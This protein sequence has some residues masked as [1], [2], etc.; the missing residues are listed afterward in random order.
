MTATA[1][2]LEIYRTAIP[3]R[4]FEHA[5]AS[6]DV[7]EAVLVR[8]GFSDGSAGWGETLPRRYVTGETIDTVIRNLSDT[9]WPACE[10]VGFGELEDLTRIPARAADGRCMHAAACAFE[11]A[12]LDRIFSGG[13]GPSLRR[14]IGARVSGVIGSADAGKTAG[15]LRRMLWFG[16]RDFKLKL[17]F[18]DDIDAENL[19]VVHKRLGR[20]IRRRRCTLRVDVNGGWSAD[21]TPGR[22][23]GLERYGVCV[24]EQPTYCSAAR[25]AELAGKCRLPLMADESLITDADADALLAG[26]QRPW[27]NIR[28]A[29]NG[30][31]RSLKM[32][33]RAAEASVRFTLG[34]MVGESSILSAAQRRMLQL[35]PRPM[36]VEGNY[37]RFLLADDLTKKSLRFG[38]GGRLK[39]LKGSGLGVAVDAGKLGRYGERLRPTNH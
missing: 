13:A 11:L 35:A 33:R 10:Q 6:R 22:V 19:H 38:Y 8:V 32:A 14:R 28:I 27:W 29:K 9:I 31:L 20:A 30:F 4:R 34:C 7:A 5:A 18:S 21:E 1:N 16:L 2:S 36:F 39:P 23:A 17:G 37:G 12:C 3:M 24:V 25:L 26:P 15:Q